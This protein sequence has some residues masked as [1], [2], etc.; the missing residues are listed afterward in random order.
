MESKRKNVYITIFVITTI[1]AAGLAI[2]FKVDGDSKQRKIEAKLEENVG[3]NN[4][5]ELVKSEVST[6]SN[7]KDTKG[8]SQTEIVEKIVKENVF[9]PDVDS[10]KCINKQDGINEYKKRISQELVPLRCIV[11][12]DRKSATLTTDW[13]YATKAWGFIPNGGNGLYEQHNSNGFGGE[14]VD[15][16]STGWGQTSDYSTL[17]FLIYILGSSGDKHVIVLYIVVSLQLL[18]SLILLSLLIIATLSPTIMF[19]STTTEIIPMF[20]VPIILYFLFFIETYA[21]FDFKSSPSAYPIQTVATVISSPL[22]R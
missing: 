15:V 13:D 22:C 8:S 2:F 9:Y 17:L 1:I 14:I 19:L 18:N 16:I 7:K 5:D 21:P 12:D 6:N 20:I 3:A 11:N 4:G 10:S